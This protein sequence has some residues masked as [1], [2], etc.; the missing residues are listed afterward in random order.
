V[1]VLR[2]TD[3]TGQMRDLE[4]SLSDGTWWEC[5]YMMCIA[6]I[7][8]PRRQRWLPLCAPELGVREVCL[9]KVRNKVKVIAQ[10]S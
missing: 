5:V 3:Y 8:V 9:E 1:R 10:S 6:A 2:Q 4:K 7:P